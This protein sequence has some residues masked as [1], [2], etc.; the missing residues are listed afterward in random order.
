M[1]TLIIGD[2]HI[3]ERAI[4]ELAEIFA[5]DIIPLVSDS[6]F[7]RIIQLGDWFDKNTPSPMELRYSS[8]LV[9]ELQRHVKE[10]VILSGTGE[11]DLLRGVSVVEH[12]EG[13]GAHIVKGD[14]VDN[15]ILYGHWML[16]ESKQAFG[17]GKYGIKDLENYDFVFLGHQH[18]PQ[19]L[20][21]NIFHVG[22]IRYCTFN[23]VGDV[24]HVIKLDDTRKNKFDG[25]RD[26]SHCIPMVDVTDVT[27]LE[28]IDARTKVRVIF[29]SFED[30]KTH[31]SYVNKIGK[32]FFQFKI[33]MNFEESK[34]LVTSSK[35]IDGAISKSNI[36][37]EYIASI[38]DL[39]VRKMLEEQFNENV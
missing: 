32:K 24:K 17:T 29:N 5:K 3:T 11:H 25:V 34:I 33:K 6:S 37:K 7:E 2:L 36:I 13:L 28:H 10:I 39:E 27:T 15:N 35:K 18:Q 9:K 12:L 16:H 8:G 26:I 20:G 4:P 23:E 19:G 1:R 21:K 38:T 30:Y 14:F 22:S 31:A